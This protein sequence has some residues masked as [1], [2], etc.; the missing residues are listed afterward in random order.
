VKR[1]AWIPLVPI[2]FGCTPGKGGNGL[3]CVASEAIDPM[4]NQAKYDP[5]EKNAFFADRRAMRMP[6]EGAVSREASPEHGSSA[7]GE[8]DAGFLSSVPFPVTRDLLAQGRERFDIFC[9]ACH[10]LVGDGESVVA[11]QMALRPPPSLV[12][13]RIAS[14]PPGRV[15]HV[16][17]DG[18]GMMPSYRAV[19]SPR[20]RWAVAAYVRAL[21]ESQNAPIAAAPAAARAKLLEEGAL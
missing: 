7:T 3:Q 11:A 21:V 19:L 5:Y 16:A 12:G 6:P 14:F 8:S 10:G 20:E 13:G 15:F 17:T 18:Y 9:A 1:R 4:E 2:L